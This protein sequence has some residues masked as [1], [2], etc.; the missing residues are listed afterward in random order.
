MRTSKER[1]N[2]LTSTLMAIKHIDNW[3]KI[4]NSRKILS[5]FLISLLFWIYYYKKEF[6]LI[7]EIYKE[8]LIYL[9]KNCIFSWRCVRRLSPQK[10]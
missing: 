2:K 7:T 9:K 1:A 4:F 10:G 3:I 8:D 5:I 6:F